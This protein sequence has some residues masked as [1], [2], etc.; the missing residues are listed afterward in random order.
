VTDRP[1]GPDPYD[2]DLS[3]ARE[4][5]DDLGVGLVVWSYRHEPDAHARRAASDAVD[6]ID[7]AIAALHRIRA[8][9]VTETRRADDETAVRVDELLARRRD[10]PRPLTPTG[11]RPTSS[12]VQSAE[13]MPDQATP[14]RRQSGEPREAAT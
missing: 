1:P 11:D 5:V 14:G 4:A 10:G 13:V 9:L 2:A 12:P 6:A 8:R 3:A 7:A